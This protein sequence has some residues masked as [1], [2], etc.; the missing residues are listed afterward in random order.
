M[1]MDTLLD[2]LPTVLKGFRETLLLLVFSGVLAT[3]LGTILASMRVSPIPVLRAFGT[4]YVNV[5]RNTPLLLVLL[6]MLFG[7][8]RSASASMSIS[9]FVPSTRSSCSR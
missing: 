7:M 8:P 6:I 4:S 3:V 2:N 5:F 1:R 9:A